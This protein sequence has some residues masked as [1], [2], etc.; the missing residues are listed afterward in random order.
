[1]SAP[2]LKE[3]WP[4]FTGDEKLPLTAFV[5]SGPDDQQPLDTAD[6]RG[7]ETITTRERLEEIIAA[8]SAIP[9][10]TV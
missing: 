9:A 7:W 6:A 1:M 10:P 8:Q 4:Q 2:S 5:K 3:Q